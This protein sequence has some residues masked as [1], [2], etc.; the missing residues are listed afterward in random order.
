MNNIVIE[1]EGNSSGE[2]FD[3]T[4]TTDHG[5]YIL[6][7]LG[8][9]DSWKECGFCQFCYS[10]IE[11]G[12]RALG[13]AKKFASK[14]GLQANFDDFQKVYTEIYNFDIKQKIFV[15][16]SKNYYSHLSMGIRCIIASLTPK[17]SFP[18]IAGTVIYSNVMKE[19]FLSIL[20]AELNIAFI[21]INSMDEESYIESCRTVCPFICFVKKN[22]RYCLRY[23]NQAHSHFNKAFILQGIIDYLTA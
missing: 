22:N 4:Y 11:M 10:N 9:I 5:F 2:F 1:I 20:S 8:I 13:N 7:M 14:F 15:I 19:K 17:L 16:N 21:I 3:I 23:Y 6:L 18:I 12:S